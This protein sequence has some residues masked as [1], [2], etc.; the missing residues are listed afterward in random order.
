MS[1]YNPPSFNSPIF[2]SNAFSS[3]G[4]VIDDAY[5]QA[6]YLRFPTAQGLENLA[7]GS[8][9]TTATAGDNT[10]KIATTAFVQSAITTGSTTST[11]KYT[12]N[13]TFNTPTGCRFIDILLIGYGGSQGV[14]DVGPPVFYGGAGSG[15]NMGCITGFCINQNTS[16]TLSFVSTSN[17]GYVSISYTGASGLT[18][19][20][21]VFN[22]NAG[23][24]GSQ[25][26]GANGGTVNGTASVINSR[27]AN[28]FVVSGTAGLAS[29]L[30]GGGSSIPPATAGTG[31]SCPNGI[32]T[33]SNGQFGCG[34]TGNVNKGN[35][36][37][38]ITYHI[39]V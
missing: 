28:A 20:A 2:D 17:T 19:I 31:T 33:Y 12:G 6:N 30:G 14:S 32:F 38:V 11:V 5:L 23:D 26:S 35:G 36:L 16:L 13:A 3:S 8:T 1:A 24:N 7:T 15:G 9:T 34:G 4:T 10:T 27:S 39:G 29:T 37:I 18:N 25:G 21:K 22:G